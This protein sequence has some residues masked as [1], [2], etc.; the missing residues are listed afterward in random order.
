[1][2]EENSHNNTVTKH[3]NL[4]HI[5]CPDRCF[6]TLN[7]MKT[8]QK[9]LKK[10]VQLLRKVLIPIGASNCVVETALMILSSLV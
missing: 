9:K 6:I 5:F 3:S 7:G 4:M 8:P 10:S 2:S 1:M